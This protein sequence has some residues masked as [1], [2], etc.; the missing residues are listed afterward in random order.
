MHSLIAAMRVWALPALVCGALAVATASRSGP[1]DFHY[2]SEE[3]AERAVALASLPSVVSV[4]VTGG[5]TSTQRGYRA[6]VVAAGVTPG[7]SALLRCPGSSQSMSVSVGGQLLCGELSWTLLAAWTSDDVDGTLSGSKHG[8]GFSG[9]NEKPAPPPQPPST[10]AAAGTTAT[11]VVAHSF[12]RW[13]VTAFIFSDG[14]TTILRMPV[15]ELEGIDQPWFN[16]TDSTLS[17]VSRMRTQLCM[18]LTD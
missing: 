2:P 5:A 8:A 15:G 16:I 7:A 6:A 11:A 9:S 13:G 14:S 1:E 4:G 12:A 18:P 3:P 10:S 17:E